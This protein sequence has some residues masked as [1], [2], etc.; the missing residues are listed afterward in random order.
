MKFPNAGL[1]CIGHVGAAVPYWEDTLSQS[2]HLVDNATVKVTLDYNL[3]TVV[4]A[5]GF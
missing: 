4:L 2:A 3:E 1:F 5:I